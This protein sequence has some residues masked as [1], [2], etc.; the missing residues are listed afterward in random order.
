MRFLY[1]VALALALALFGCSSGSRDVA[2]AAAPEPGA[3]DPE[4]T[5]GT[6]EPAPGTNESPS[7]T[8]PPPANANGDIV[9]VARVVDSGPIGDGRCQQCS[10]RI[11]VEETLAGDLGA[12]TLWA[13]YEACG[14]DREPP[15]GSVDPCA[16][17]RGSTYELRL[18]RGASENYGN[19]PMILA[20]R[21]R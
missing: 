18:R 10:H 3:G 5:P 20:A 2:P 16:M 12:D 14:D 6:D 13:H 21:P 19:D 7:E 15:P 4:G 17:R 9:V 11:A 1:L 8:E